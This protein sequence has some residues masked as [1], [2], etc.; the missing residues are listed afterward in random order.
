VIYPLNIT[1]STHFRQQYLPYVKA[2]ENSIIV[3]NKKRKSLTYP[4]V[5]RLLYWS[6]RRAVSLLRLSYL[7][8]MFP[9][10]AACRQKRKTLK[11]WTG[12]WSL[13]DWK[14]TDDHKSRGWKMQDWKMTDEVYNQY[15]WQHIPVLKWYEKKTVSA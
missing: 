14:M 5:I 9:R 15:K 2:S 12:D 6:M 13:Q 8:L 10:C 3:N 4:P 7:S 1:D 11:L